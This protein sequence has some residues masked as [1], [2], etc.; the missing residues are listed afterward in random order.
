MK[1][2]I[3]KKN[4]PIKIAIELYVIGNDDKI[5]TECPVKKC[6]H[7]PRQLVSSRNRL[8]DRLGC[9]GRFRLDARVFISRDRTVVHGLFVHLWDD[10][11][12]RDGLPHDSLRDDSL[13]DDSLRDGSLPVV[14]RDDGVR[15]GA[16]LDVRAGPH[17]R[18]HLLSPRRYPV[19]Y[20]H[21]TLPTT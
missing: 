5:Q 10:S 20:T 15:D 14:R 9:R 2:S 18:L 11:R 19:S 8:D 4:S 21:L 7:D 16:P 12:A 6:L 17:A 3:G 13:R 1:R